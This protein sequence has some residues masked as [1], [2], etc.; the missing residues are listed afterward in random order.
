MFKAILD[1]KNAPAGYPLCFNHQCSRCQ[2]CL[3]Y[4]VAQS[5][6][7][8]RPYGRTVLPT[9]WADGECKC[10]KSAEPQELAWGFDKLYEKLLPYQKSMARSTLRLYFSAGMSTYYRYHYGEKVLSVE[11]QK[12]ILDIMSEY[13]SRDQFA[14]DNYVTSLD[15]SW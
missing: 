3:H 14:F 5:K 1:I 4:Q 11:Q 13:G 6:T 15:F 2:E 8:R 7:P 9:A 10:F 12:D